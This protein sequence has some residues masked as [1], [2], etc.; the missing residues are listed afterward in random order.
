VDEA[1]VTTHRLRALAVG[2]AAVVAFAPAIAGSASA[3]TEPAELEA[4]PSL[5]L[6]A[7]MGRW[8]QVAW[9]PNRFQRQCVS[10]TEAIYRALPEGLVEVDNRCRRADGQMES[11][12]GAARPADAV[13]HGDELRPATLQV[14]F[15]PSFLRWLPVG[16]APYWVIQL[17]EDGRY[18]VVSEPTREYLWVLSRTPELSSADE[19]AIRSRLQQQ[20]FDLSRWQA[21]PQTTAG[22]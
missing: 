21:H 22:R 13:R 10:D 8:Y 9:F 4:L 15:L 12:L 11:I 18:S 1:P 17:A 14:S 19:T 20:G 7:Y 3:A 5:N 6:P 16:W 2:L